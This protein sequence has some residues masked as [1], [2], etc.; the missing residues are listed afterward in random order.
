LWSVDA[1]IL[2]VVQL[3]RIDLQ[4]EV[5]FFMGWSFIFQS[6]SCGF[7]QLMRFGLLHSIMFLVFLMMSRPRSVQ[8]T[9]V[10]FIMLFNNAR[11]KIA[12]PTHG[13]IFV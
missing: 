7:L 9:P 5:S 1:Q 10:V 4:Q 12:H 3:A 6:F 11:D 8:R 13:C 2:F